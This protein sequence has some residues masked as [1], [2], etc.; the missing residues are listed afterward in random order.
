MSI[1]TGIFILIISL[2][3]GGYGVIVGAGG[4]FILVPALL[5]LFNVSPPVA[6]GTGLVIVLIN[7]LTGVI[8]YAQQKS[9]DYQVGLKI[10]YG[11]IPG[12]LLGV[13]LLQVQPTD[14]IYFYIL[15]GTLLFCLGGFLFFKNAPATWR[16]ALPF[17]NGTKQGNERRYPPLTA[18]RLVPLGVLMGTLSSYLGIGGGWLLVPILIYMFRVPTHEAA[19][20]S[21]FTLSLY[22]MVGVASHVYYQTIDWAIIVWGAIGVIAGAY[23]G[24][25]LAKKISGP[26]ILQMLSI[27]LMIM[28]VRMVF[29]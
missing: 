26:L 8:G 18:S 24:V 22:T 10:V 5:I 4:G 13:W 14:S 12:S 23:I 29:A 28:G 19:A 17:L 16:N 7:S 11:A 27:L 6:A 3:A 1:T 15:F 2:I 21:I 9:I 25:R 20:T